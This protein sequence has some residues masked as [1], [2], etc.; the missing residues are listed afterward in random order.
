MSVLVAYCYPSDGV[1]HKDFAASLEELYKHDAGPKGRHIIGGQ[2]HV[3]GLYIP[4]SRNQVCQ[5]FLDAKYPPEVQQ[6]LGP[7]PQWLLFLDTDII[8]KPEDVYALIDAADPIEK[9]IVGGLYFGFMEGSPTPVWRK[10][11]HERGL[12]NEWG[13]MNTVTIGVI[14]PID[15]VGMGFTLIHRSVLEGMP[16]IEGDNWRWFGHDCWKGKRLGEDL[17]FC[18]RAKQHGFVTWGDSR[19]VVGHIKP[20][21]IRLEHF[22]EAAERHKHETKTATV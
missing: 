8:F 22:I 14:E 3:R 20:Y 17:T 13:T 7:K 1:I 21:T 15:A 4:D 9:P 6:W 18:A 19:V 16:E 10:I 2:I 11:Y 12:D 5:R